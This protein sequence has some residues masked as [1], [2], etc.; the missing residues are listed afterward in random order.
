MSEV[1]ESTTEAENEDKEAPEPV[2]LG[3]EEDISVSEQCERLASV[4]AANLVEIC[5]RKS[6]ENQTVAGSNEDIG[7][8]VER[9]ISSLNNHVKTQLSLH[10]RTLTTR[11]PGSQPTPL[12][13]RINGNC[14][15]SDYSDTEPESPGTLAPAKHR[16]FFRRFS[17]KGIKKSRALNFFH[18][19]G[20]DEAEL[21]SAAPPTPVQRPCETKKSKMSKIIV[22]CQKEGLVNLIADVAMDGNSKWEKSKMVLVKATGGFMIEFYTPPKMSRP[23]TGVFCFLISEARETTALEMPDKENTFVIKTENH[24]EYIVEA[25]DPEEMRTWLAVIHVCMRQR[26]QG[27][28]LSLGLTNKMYGGSGIPESQSL[29]HFQSGA[30]FDSLFSSGSPAPPQLSDLPARIAGAMQSGPGQ[31]VDPEVFPRLSEFPWF[32]GTLARSDAAAMVLHQSIT[33]HGVFLVRQ[34]ETRR[35]EYVL[36]FNFQGRAKH[37]RMALNPDGQCRVQHMWFN[38]I[39]DMLEHFRVHSI[40]LESGASSDCTLTEYAV[41][42]DTIPANSQHTTSQSSDSIGDRRLPEPNE[43]LEV[44]DIYVECN[45]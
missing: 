35:G 15:F 31:E 19:Q 32:H 14:T 24:Q 4:T 41:R 2:I 25:P 20:S 7:L 29:Q 27:A 16:P 33:G 22:E 42:A 10:N 40:P 17:F 34:S 44:S 23:K 37:I 43:V 6:S 12:D 26:G 1:T 45:L 28:D 9:F 38:T 3:E 36:T 13:R 30:R 8:T 39:F 11:T 18:K 21:S 5:L